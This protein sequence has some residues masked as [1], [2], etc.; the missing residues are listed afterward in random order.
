MI[1]LTKGPK[2]Q[3]LVDNEL[4][5][6]DEFARWV[7]KEPG[8][9]VAAATRYRHPAIKAAL[10][11]ESFDKC[12]YC[13]SKVSHV[14]PGDCEHIR[15]KSLHP[16]L[17]VEWQNL[18]YVCAECNRA[19]GDYDNTA[20]PLLNPYTSDPRT[21]LR[22]IGPLC[23]AAPGDMPGLTT[24]I[25][26]KLGRAALVE[27]RKEKLERLQDL[28]WTWG[29]LPDGPTKD[30]LLVSVRALAADDQEYSAAGAAF[31]RGHGLEP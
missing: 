10:R 16:D 22:F 13:E 19:K 6:T 9:P 28:L 27:R 8:I 17:V 20:E 25:T 21:H 31:L 18:A 24:T 5:W 11:S 15:P 7:A 26:L 4:A 30:G 2:P 3:V 12:V 1:R 14:Y 29:S 23:F